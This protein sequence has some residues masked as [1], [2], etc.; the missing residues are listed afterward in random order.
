M[1][2]NK[3]PLALKFDDATGNATGLV[4]FRIDESQDLSGLPVSSLSGIN[5]S[6]VPS[7]GQGLVFTNGVLSNAA[8]GGGGG[9]GLTSVNLGYN[10]AAASGQVTN[11]AGS[12]ADLPAATGSDAGLLLPAEKT[13]L[14]DIE[15]DADVTDTDNVTAAGALMRSGGTMTGAT[16]FEGVTIK[17]IAEN[18]LM[19]TDPTSGVSSVSGPSGTIPYFT[20]TTPKPVL[21]GI[22]TIME[23]A[24]VRVEDKNLGN[25][26]DTYS[27]SPGDGSILYRQ[28][29]AW[30]AQRIDIVQSA[31][32][33]GGGDDGGSPVKFDHGG[34]SGLGDDDHTQYVLSAGTRAMSALTVNNNISTSGIIAKNI[35]PNSEDGLNIR[36]VNISGTTSVSSA[37]ITGTN[38]TATT[39]VSAPTVRAGT[40]VIGT[41]GSF[42]NGSFTNVTGTAIQA[43]TLTPFAGESDTELSITANDINLSGNLNATSST[44]A[45]AGITT[46]LHRE[47]GAP[48]ASSNST[49][50]ADLVTY[51]LPANA[52]TLGDIDITIRG[53]QLAQG[54]NLRWNFKIGGTNILN[55]AFSQ[56]TYSDMTAY[57]MDIQ[58]SK[59]A[60]DKQ[61]VTANFRQSTGSSSAA[62]RGSWTGIHRD[63]IIVNYDSAGDESTALALTLQVQQSDAAQIATVD[64]FTVKLVPDPY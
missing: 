17:T 32:G 9:G 20:G 27:T 36:A 10:A 63:G 45:N 19:V 50:L 18:S 26:K 29:G 7:D 1:G 53:R 21:T 31:A 48:V 11:D 58:I 15:A 64:Q 42:T 47:V 25:L 33:G 41:L 39:Q 22:P 44:L 4:E 8:V 37:S 12:A 55:S 3:I 2:F 34:L 5:L 13:K 61:L 51:T 62:G 23:E 52:L 46:T 28:G 35:V 59:T 6:S 49:S 60:T 54:S 16:T 38:V 14:A 30:T 43:N 56:G 57:T 24:D 40:S